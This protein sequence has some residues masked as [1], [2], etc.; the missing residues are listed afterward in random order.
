MADIAALLILRTSSAQ[1]AL[2]AYLLQCSY[3]HLVNKAMDPAIYRTFHNQMTGLVLR[4]EAHLIYN[5]FVK[6]VTALRVGD[7]T[8]EISQ[9]MPGSLLVSGRGIIDPTALL[10]KKPSRYKF[11]NDS[12]D[13]LSEY[14]QC[15]Y[16]A[17]T[18]L[19]LLC[20]GLHD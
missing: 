15:L 2:L 8:V 18:A 19:E 5:A 20:Y 16:M 10:T 7:T 4:P 11:A 6:K 14:I 1:Q 17:T 3:D 9:Q 12:Y 13:D